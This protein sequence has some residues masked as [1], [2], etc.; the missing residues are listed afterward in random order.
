MRINKFR[1]ANKVLGLKIEPISFSNLSLLVGVSGVGKTMILE[2]LTKLK[3]IA[4]GAALNGIE[5]EIFFSTTPKKN[6]QWKGSFETTKNI[7]SII[8]IPTVGKDESGETMTERPKIKYEELRLNDTLIA[9]RKENEI[10]LKGKKTPKL[11]SYQS[12]LYLFNEEAI[13]KP[14]FENLNKIIMSDHS[15]QP[16]INIIG[17]FE[18]LSTKYATTESIKNSSMLT[19]A[20]LALAYRSQPD[21]F[22]KIKANFI[23][24]FPQIEDIKFEPFDHPQMFFRDGYCLYIKEK[25]VSDWIFQNISSGMFKTLMQISDLFLC[26]EGAVILIDEFENSLGIN[27][28]D[29]LIE[30]LLH[31]SSDI[32]FIIT[33]HHP[34]IINSIGMEHWKVVSRNGGTITTKD[35]KDFELGKSRHEA[36]KQLIQLAEYREGIIT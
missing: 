25:N 15:H 27:C 29:T 24:V 11:S 2:A 36:F 34:Y 3:Q 26:P 19:H 20:K 28:I 12:L 17:D 1:Y 7:R 32:Q 31:D 10:T 22:N 14:I 6:Y 8:N 33:S 18:R 21:I 13:I 5:W 16:G 4:Q 35:A 23:N 30:N 9:E